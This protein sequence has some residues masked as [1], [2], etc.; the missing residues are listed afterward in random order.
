MLCIGN[1][2]YCTSLRYSEQRVRDIQFLREELE[3]RLEEVLE[4]IDALVA[5]KTRLERALEACWD[6]LRVARLCL[7]ER[8]PSL[9]W[10]HARSNINLQ[11][12]HYCSLMSSHDMYH[13]IQNCGKQLL[14]H[15][16]K[17]YVQVHIWG[18][19]L[20]YFYFLLHYTSTPLHLRGKYCTKLLI[21]IYLTALVTSYFAD[22]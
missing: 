11:T 19:L 18:T 6:P 17:Y 7:H 21:Y 14:V 10:M 2:T 5:F 13:F 22:N 4:E 16:L 1:T 3:R 12:C 20:E 8:W 15:L 9:G